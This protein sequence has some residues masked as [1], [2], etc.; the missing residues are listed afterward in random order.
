MRKIASLILGL[1][2]L[3][4]ISNAKA[5]EGM[6]LLSLLKKNASEMQQMGLQLSPDD[7]YNINNSSL[8]DALVGLGSEGRPFRHFCTGEI[9]SDQGLFLTNHHCGYGAIQSHSTPEHDYLSDGF[10]A[11]SKEE[12]LTNPG[13]TASILVRMEDVT[14]KVLSELKDEMTEEERYNAVEKI[15]IEIEKAAEEGTDYKANVKSMFEGNQYFLFVYTIY[16][17]VRLVGAP[18]SS[19][20]KFGGDTDNWMW[21]RHTADF[22]MF[23][24]YTGPDGKP[25]EYSENNIPLKPNHHLPVSIKGVEEKDF[26]MIMGFPGTTD[27]YLTSYGLEETMKI[28]NQNR[29][30][31]RTLKLKLLKEDMSKDAK[32]RIQYASKYAGSANYWKY[33]NEQNKALAKL[34]TIDN[35][36]KVEQEFTTWAEK[37]SKRTEKYGSALNLIE[38]AYK[39]R[40]DAKFADSYLKEALFQGPEAPMFAV[41]A[42]GLKSL[43]SEKTQNNE[44]IEK[45]IANLRKSASEFYKDYNTSTDQKLMAGMYKM[46]AEKVSIDEQPEIFKF[47][48]EEYNNNFEKFAADVYA[49]S[50]FATEESF[51]KFLDAP[52]LETLENDLAYKIGNSIMDSYKQLASKLEKGNDDL[53]KGK[54]LFVDGLLQINKDKVMAPDANSTLR[55]TYGSVGGYS[56]KDAVY[57]KHFTTLKGVM[58]KEDATDPEFEVPAKLK[59]LYQNKNYGRYADK[60]GELHTCFL[61]NNDITGG[62]SGSPVINAK[63]ELIGAAFDGNSE[64][65]SGDIDFEDNLQKCINVDIR[66]VLFIIDKYAGAQNL[67]DEMTIVK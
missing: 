44:V 37:K 39:D 51:S 27:R 53:K 10:W 17:D 6:W 63:G 42:S 30:D 41:H 35:K 3:L 7:I 47:I 16:K 12:E 55:L 54:R 34:N 9:I 62:N 15:S 23:R 61:T 60:D 13:I 14:E 32:V 52:E 65:M 33:S 1:S 40:E 11:Y 26:A 28:I 22:S 18:P 50:I 21:P 19:M 59:E 45:S 57:Y 64:A 66:Y 49:K 43:L 31:I 4:S 29:Y 2:L 67:I 56:P 24:I 5:D 58:E 25:A 36:R 48:A 38:N 8:K 20:G 46:Y